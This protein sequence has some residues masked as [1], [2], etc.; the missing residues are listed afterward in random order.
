MFFFLIRLRNS[1]ILKDDNVDMNISNLKVLT[2]PSISASNINIAQTEH[3]FVTDVTRGETIRD[4][5]GP[6]KQIK[7]DIRQAQRSTY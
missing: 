2:F 7:R 6:Q 5:D 3:G 1:A 4:G